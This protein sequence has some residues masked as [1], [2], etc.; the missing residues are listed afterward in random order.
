M[1]DFFISCM[2]DLEPLTGIRQLY[3]I[4]SDLEDGAR[5]FNVLIEGM[6]LKSK[7]Y[8]Y[9]PEE[10]QKAII[11]KMMVQDHAYENLNSRTVDKW[12]NMHK[13]KWTIKE[14]VIEFKPVELTNEAKERVDALLQQ[15]RASL[16]GQKP[17]F[18]G[19]EQDMKNIE[20][21]DAQRMQRP[22]AMPPRAFNPGDVRSEKLRK[23]VIETKGALWLPKKYFFIGKIDL[24]GDI[25]S[26]DEVDHDRV[27]RF[28]DV[29]SDWI[30]IGADS[31]EEA[32]ELYK[33]THKA[34][35]DCPRCG[36]NCK[37][38]CELN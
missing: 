29:C 23:I 28:Q 14:Q 1:R 35:T 18:K 13:D 4:E 12:L 6:V 19:I 16:I 32:I 24:T 17:S 8:S 25:I 2:K 26:V 31:E 27:E 21:E 20:Q 36:K 33:T 34:I 15:Y 7:E 38:W 10:A 37:G 5:K 30:R 22:K 11:K 9:I 3:Y